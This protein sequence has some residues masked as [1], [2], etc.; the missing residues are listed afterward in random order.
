MLVNIEV[1]VREDNKIIVLIF[2]IISLFLNVGRLL[3][4]R[5]EIVVID[6]YNVM[7]VVFFF[8][9]IFLFLCWLIFLIINVNCFLL[10]V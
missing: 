3:F 2:F 5:M 1:E 6:I 4:I 9:L 8:V 10:S 7:E